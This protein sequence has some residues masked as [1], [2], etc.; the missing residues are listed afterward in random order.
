MDEIKNT[1]INPSGNTKQDTNLGDGLGGIAG[2][3][4]EEGGEWGGQKE[5]RRGRRGGEGR[6][7]L[8]RLLFLGGEDK[9]ALAS[10]SPLSRRYHVGS[11]SGE[12]K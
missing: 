8:F 2:G 7:E 3:V 9:A 11:G 4:E 10:S 12:G 6:R 5:W 1:T